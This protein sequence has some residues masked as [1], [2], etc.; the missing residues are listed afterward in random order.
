MSNLL[1]CE[2]CHK[3]V[4]KTMRCTCG[5]HLCIDCIIERSHSTVYDQAHYEISKGV[6]DYYEPIDN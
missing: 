6:G 4:N 1:T 3:Q 5:M 2:Q